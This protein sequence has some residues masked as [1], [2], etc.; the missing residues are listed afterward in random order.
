MVK[1]GMVSL[2]LSM[3][4]L[5]GHVALRAADPIQAALHRAA[6]YLGE[7]QN[8]DGGYG[9]YGEKGRLENSSDVGITGLVLYALAR[10]PRDYK[11]IDGPFISEAVAYLL[12]MQQPDGGFYDS[13]DPVLQNY[14]TCVAVMALARLDRGK[15]A[16]A[17]RKAQKFIQQQQLYETQRYR[18][19]SHASYGA[20]GYGGS[21]LRGD[22]SNSGMSAEALAESGVSASDPLWKRLESFV[23]RCQNMPSVDPLLARAGIGTTGDG[24]FRYAPND[25]RGPVESLDG[26]RVF[27]SYGSMTYQGLKSLLHA[28]V[29]RADPRVLRAF[30]WIAKNFTVKENPG[31]ASSYEPK[32]GQQGLFYYYYTMAKTLR[33]Y[34]EPII[35]DKRGVKHDWARELS[36]HLLSL[37]HEDG[38]WL[39]TSGRW[40]ENIKALDTSYVMVA[41]SICREELARQAQQEK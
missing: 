21:S 36:Q 40:W 37:Q 13:R 17:I 24:G 1:R 9:P 7:Q 27:S 25:T 8:P 15:Y 18:L 14:R 20:Y 41:L 30:D 2:G 26:K 38:Y 35:V 19:T 12:S 11:S 31:M 3:V 32:A 23:S 33:I 28:N 29:R 34:G 39:N 10:H 22:L 5:A 6:R 4:L 16:D